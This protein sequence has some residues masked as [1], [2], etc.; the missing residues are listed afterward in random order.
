MDHLEEPLVIPDP[1]V[2]ADRIRALRA[3][4]DDLVRLH[5][6]AVSAYKFRLRQQNRGRLSR[7][8]DGGR[9]A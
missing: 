4:L 5:K 9:D 1:A 7:D 2:L 8:A 6:I 3:E